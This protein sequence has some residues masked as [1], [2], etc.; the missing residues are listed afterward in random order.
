MYQNECQF[1]LTSEIKRRFITIIVC[2]VL[3]KY[4]PF[5]FFFFLQKSFCIFKK[6]MCVLCVY[7]VFIINTPCSLCLY[8]YFQKKKY[9]FFLFFGGLAFHEICTLGDT[10]GQKHT[11]RKHGK[12]WSKSAQ[13][14]HPVQI[15]VTQMDCSNQTIFDTKWCC[16]H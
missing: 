2:I 6:F 10:F 16:T 15:N 13:K 1:I 8:F 3:C 14:C 11:L 7:C 12:I 5:F 9:A 4:F